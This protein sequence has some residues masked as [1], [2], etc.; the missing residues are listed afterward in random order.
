MQAETQR[1]DWRD[2]GA[3]APLLRADRSLVAWEWLRR[4]ARYASAAAEARC[5]RHEHS[6]SS[7]ARFGLVEFEPCERRVPD[8]R[9]VWASS[10]YPYVLNAAATGGARPQDAFDI[11]R[12]A[13]LATLGRDQFGEHLLLSDGLR[14]LRIDAPPGT[15]ERGPKRLCFLL[16][17]IAAAQGPLLTL[18]RFLALCSTGTFARSLHRSEPRARRWVLA[19]RAYDALL[20]G[21][22]Q[23]DIAQELLSRTAGEPRWR[24][25]ESSIRSQAQRLVR[26]ARDFAAGGFR[27]LLK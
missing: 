17:G 2:A 25:R 21:A 1:P 8:A 4:D 26:S 5:T 16:E 15:F 22:G 3:Y 9:P 11:E 14:A 18:R 27:L 20:A 6:R 19:L 10:I 24:S 13:D 7:A 12:F 23:R